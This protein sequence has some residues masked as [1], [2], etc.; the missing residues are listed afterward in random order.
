MKLTRI[1]LQDFRCF[2]EAAFDLKVPG[3]EEPL[4][5]V[6]FVGPNGT[7]KSSVIAALGGLFT[8]F[9]GFYGADRLALDD[10]RAGRDMAKISAEWLDRVE[11]SPE[12][13][14]AVMGIFRRPARVGTQQLPAGVHNL[15]GEFDFTAYARWQAAA[16]DSA[17]RETGLMVS[18]DVYRLLPP[19]AVA[20]PNAQQ[21]V[22]HRLQGAMESSVLRP[23]FLQSQG[24]RFRDLKQWIVNLDFQRAKA[25][26][27]RGE[28]SPAWETLR[29]AIDTIFD[30]FKFDRVDERFEVL[31]RT[32]T[33]LV[34]I[35]ALSDGFRSVF[36]I[37]T[38]LLFRLSLTT[39]DPNRLVQQE[40]VC[41]IDEID[42]HLHP[43]WQE[44]ALPGL[45]ELFP[46][47]QFIATTHSPI[48][49]STVAPSEVFR[50]QQEEE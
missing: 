19:H 6:L 18:F 23:G 44:R 2:G 36:V 13:F 15:V 49:V 20:G 25:K 46:N 29:K 10:V 28:E 8:H 26:A 17:P 43:R 21:V 32:P 22:S 31:I 14:S 37:V 11:E 16:L 12:P 1:E 48:V 34:P 7:G 45:R 50:F 35:E 9:S 41:L 5:T 39:D 33:G 40:A 24:Q 30:P 47:V 4:S 27:D 38:E 42:A 3:E